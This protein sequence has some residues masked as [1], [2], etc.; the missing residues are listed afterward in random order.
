MRALT[1]T[2]ATV[3]RLLRDRT[4]LFFTIMLPVAIILIV[5]IAVGGS[6][7]VRV[8]VVSPGSGPITHGLT[9]A[10]ATSSS[11]SSHSYPSLDAAKTAARRQEVDAVVVIPATLD[12]DAH[13]GR[14]ISIPVLV[15]PG[16]TYG[17]TAISAV[18]AV[19]ANQGAALQAARF[20][21]TVNGGTV[22]D[23]LP[24]ATALQQHTPLITV[25]TQTLNGQNTILPA[26]YSYSTPTMLVLFVFI[27]T[28]TSG[29][30]MVR[31]RQLGIYART[32]A[33]PA[34]P[35]AIVLGELL[36]FLTLA[37]LQSAL[38]VGIGALVFGVHWGDPA[39]AAV[40]VGVWALVGTGA[41]VLAGTLFRTPEQAS[42]IGPTLGMG[43]GMLGGCMWPLAIVTPLMRTVGHLTPQSWAVDA[44]T[45]L[46]SRG[47]HLTDLGTQLGVLAAFAATLLALATLSLRR[48]LT[49]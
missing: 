10:L 5:G 17:Q 25:A 4:A 31:T 35:G 1:I 40:L 33:S 48:R 38:I 39:A 28:M 9:A 37:L 15:E 26:G 34:G 2:R 30:I 24:T 8:A 41:G 18:A 19:V 47:G 29:A 22:T 21:A 6:T 11:L 27:N 46:I 14:P 16:S 43:L 42:A 13:A 20:A 32:L 45:I 3:T 23:H 36:G 49:A 7:K 44:W 12:Q